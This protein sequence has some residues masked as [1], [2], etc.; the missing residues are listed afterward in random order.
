MII[1]KLIFTNVEIAWKHF[2]YY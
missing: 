2:R 1:S